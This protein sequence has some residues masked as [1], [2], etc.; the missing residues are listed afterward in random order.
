MTGRKL[1]ILCDGTFNDPSDGT[2]VFRLRSAAAGPADQLVYY[3]PGVGIPEM[4]TGRGPIGRFL[5]RWAGGAFGYGISKNVMQ[6]YRWICQHYEP[7]DHL[8]FLGFSRG[9]FTARSV[10]GMIRKIG[11]LGPDLD[12]DTLT[13]AFDRYRDEHHPNCPTID[14]YRAAQDSTEVGEI[15]IHF[16]GVWDTVGALGVP[17]IGLRTLL[18]ARRWEF[19]DT[20]LSSHVQVARQA[21]AIDE[22]RAAFLPA[23]WCADDADNDVQQ[24]WF[25][26]CHSDIGGRHGWLGFEWMVGELRKFGLDVEEPPPPCPDDT[27]QTRHESL[28]GYWR[29][30]AGAVDRA[31][32]QVREDGTPSFRAEDLA[33]SAGQLNDCRREDGDCCAEHR[34]VVPDERWSYARAG[35]MT[36]PRR[37]GWGFARWY[38]LRQYDEVCRDGDTSPC[39]DAYRDWLASDPA[40]PATFRCSL[41]AEQQAALGG[42][43][44]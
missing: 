35:T 4:D 17:V 15:C 37:S 32:Q 28:K 29:F 30:G 7:G 24:R 8:Y 9:A 38:Y 25:A 2:N 14:A 39:C 5:E 13:E 43:A 18:A 31:V 11:L 19:H 20:R 36:R 27:V 3:D 34:A 23:P 22:R 10:V 40:K 6:A 21:L 16:L 12:W 44:D 41:L 26:G 33:A 1:V 42:G